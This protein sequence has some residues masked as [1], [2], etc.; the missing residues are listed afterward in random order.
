MEQFDTAKKDLIDEHKR[1][2]MV[3]NDRTKELQQIIKEKDLEIE[4]WKEVADNK[5][6]NGGSSSLRDLKL[7]TKEAE[8]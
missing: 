4:E 3:F 6:K 5:I 7:K 1:E 2:I 8:T